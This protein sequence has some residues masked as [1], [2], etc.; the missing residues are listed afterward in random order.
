MTKS[1]GQ[2]SLT[3]PTPNSGD[4]SPIHPMIYVHS[5]ETDDSAASVRSPLGQNTHVRTLFPWSKSPLGQ[6]PCPS[7]DGVWLSGW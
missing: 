7:I 1:G 6:V 2:F 5:G 3:S 4:E